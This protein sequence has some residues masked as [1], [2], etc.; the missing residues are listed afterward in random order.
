MSIEQL[1]Q[2]IPDYAKDIR[3]NVGN[4]FGNIAQSG[5]TETQFYGV[6]LS[7]AYALKNKSMIHAIKADGAT[8]LSPELEQ[9][10]K[11]A[12]ALMTMNNIAWS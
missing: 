10:V 12:M 1:K 3:L 7:V 9:A 11:T 8:Y 6:A 2:T 4:L 5:L